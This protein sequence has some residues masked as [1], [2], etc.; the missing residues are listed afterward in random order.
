[1]KVERPGRPGVG[2]VEQSRDAGHAKSVEQ[3]KAKAPEER[4]QVSSLSK[5]ISA[6]RAN[7]E[8]VDQAKVEQL[9]TDIQSGNFKVD[10]NKVADAMLREEM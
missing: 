8:A 3:A 10:H 6:F 7:P 2:Q 4:I 5:L 1:M 9:K